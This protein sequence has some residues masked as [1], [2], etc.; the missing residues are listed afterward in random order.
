MLEY[1]ENLKGIQNLLSQKQSLNLITEDE[2][3]LLKKTTK[4]ISEID[5]LISEDGK[6]SVK[7]FNTYMEAMAT[8]TL[9]A[10]ESEKGALEDIANSDSYQTWYSNLILLANGDKYL[11]DALKSL[12]GTEREFLGLTSEQPDKLGQIRTAIIATTSEYDKL[13]EKIK[14]ASEQIQSLDDAI[15]KNKDENSTFSKSEILELLTLYP[16]L[17]DNILKSADGYKIEEAALEELRNAKVEELK[18]TLKAEIQK[19]QA[20]LNG[21]ANRLR[22]YNAEI[23][24]IQNV[25]QAQKELAKSQLINTILQQQPESEIGLDVKN[26]QMEKIQLLT[27]FVD[28][29]NSLQKSQDDLDALNFQTELL[30]D[31]FGAVNDTT[32]NVDDQIK[33]I[34]QNL[35]NTT[36]ELEKSV[37]AMEDGQAE[38]NSLLETTV[39]MLKKK[40]ELNKKDYENELKNLKTIVD[41][42][43]QLLEIEKENYDFQKSLKEKTTEVSDIKIK[44]ETLS[45]D[46]SM[47]S[48]K[49]RLEL[50][51]QLAE[52]E[53]ALSEFLSNKDIELKKEALDT[54]YE[55]HEKLIGD[56][57]QS[58]D[59]FLSKEGEIYKEAYALIDGRTEEFYN[60]LL[61]YTQT[62]TNMTMVEFTNMWDRAY[63]ALLTY[64]NGQIN[65]VGTL[66]NLQGQIAGLNMHIENMRNQAEATISSLEG[67]AR[68]FEKIALERNKIDTSPLYKASDFYKQPTQIEWSGLSKPTQDILRKLPK[69]HDGGKVEPFTSGYIGNNEVL[70]KLLTGEVVTT[71]K[72]GL[73]F[74]RN[75]LPNIVAGAMSTKDAQQS[76]IYNINMPEITITGDATDNTVSKIKQ[77]LNEY[78]E[79]LFEEINRSNKKFGNT[80][81]V[82]Y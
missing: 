27:E 51:E 28:V 12:I 32:G 53:L 39:A 59:D 68:A 75:T 4:E 65:I 34:N 40:Y 60:S 16:T 22:A 81:A 14:L 72:Q 11:E 70:A 52:K 64:G 25:Q 55:N 61:N 21:I 46:D 71:P 44:I 15:T 29:G 58:I 63:Q 77:S 49:E 45:L 5:K 35:E 26:K 54:E 7:T 78:K 8:K 62:Y 43:K 48:V 23:V 74:L 80:L 13:K 57:I 31:K 6:Y 56:K 1:L 79:N 10:Y 47:E 69:F 9:Y 82:K 38:I 76:N 67:M 30:D 42:K 3:K 2:Q 73:S 18:T 36:K 66:G 37:K 41:K 17:V 24:G 20:T 50:K 33:N 19:S